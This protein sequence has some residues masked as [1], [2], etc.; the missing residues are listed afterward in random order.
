[1]VSS[2]LIDKKKTTEVDKTP[3]VSPYRLATHAGFAYF[4][5]GVCLWNSLNLLRKPQE[6]V[7]TSMQKLSASTLHFKQLMRVS[8]FWLTLVL[9]TGFFTAGTSAG[10]SCNTFPKVG[11]YWFYSQKHFI[12]D[13]PLWQNFTENKLICQ[14]NHRT[15]ALLMTSV[16]SLVT[17][18]LCRLAHL[19]PAAKIS[20]IM[21]TV[22]CWA[23]VTI[24]ANVIWNSVPIELASMHQIGAMTV[25]TAFVFSQHCARRIDP[26]HM[27]TLMQRLQ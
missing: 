18:K 3:R 8:H 11:P 12:S 6:A 23:Q 16:I 1:M 26:R 14:V 13:I 25:L 9:L 22:A 27:K 10:Y 2:G 5:Y 4:L 21:L 7:I 15:A 24:G 19:T 20:L 17:L